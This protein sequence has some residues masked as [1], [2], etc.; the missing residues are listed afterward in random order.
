MISLTMVSVIKALKLTSA[1]SVEYIFKFCSSVGQK[2]QITFLER[3]QFGLRD[4][5]FQSKV[6]SDHDC[7]KSNQHYKQVKVKTQFDVGHT[8]QAPSSLHNKIT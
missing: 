4:T 7:W 8:Q 2:I 1:E 6:Y 3:T 5:L